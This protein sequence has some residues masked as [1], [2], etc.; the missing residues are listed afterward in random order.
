MPGDQT[1][2]TPDWL[3]AYLEKLFGR[4]VCD[5]ASSVWNAKAPD[6]LEDGLKEP[7]P[8]RTFCNPPFAQFRVWADRAMDETQGLKKRVLLVGP[9][10]VNSLWWHKMIAAG[11]ATHF[12]NQRIAYARPDPN[13]ERKSRPDRDSVILT[14]GYGSTYDGPFKILNV[15][16]AREGWTKSP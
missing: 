15:R 7:W 10:S 3:Y 11:W 9:A 13:D 2:R 4:F 1:W 16:G 6:R 8:D 5:A 12:P 14:K